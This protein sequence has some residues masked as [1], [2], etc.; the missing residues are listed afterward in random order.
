M[1]TDMGRALDHAQNLAQQLSH[2]EETYIIHIVLK[3]IGVQSSA[4]GFLYAKHTVRMLMENPNAK[5]RNGVYIA[6]GMMTTPSA[7]EQQVE[8][9]IRD[10]IRKAWRERDEQIW[11]CYFP[12]GKAGRTK[13]PSN[14]EFLFA[15][16][17]FVTMWQAFAQE[18]NY[19]QK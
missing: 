17:D 4:V 1:K 13:C 5:L 7:G 15:I 10:A 11:R 8:Q 18:V 9:A 14:R 3:E 2:C 19:A 16:V 6:A 12:N